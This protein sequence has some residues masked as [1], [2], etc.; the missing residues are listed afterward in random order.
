MCRV[1]FG[2]PEQLRD[3]ASRWPP[4]NEMRLGDSAKGRPDQIVVAGMGGSAIG[5]DL[6]AA[7]AA[8]HL[9]IPLLVWRNYRLPEFAG[10]KTLVVVS[11]YSGNTGEALSAYEEGRRRKCRLMAVTSGG[12][13][14]RRA[15]QESTEV[16]RLPQ[17]FPPRGA[18]AYSSMA[19]WAVL[20]DLKLVPD[21]RQEIFNAA[22]VLEEVALRYAPACPLERNLAKQTAYKLHGSFPVIYAA[23]DATSVAAVRWRGQLA[24]NAK[25]LSAH[26][27]L[28]EM[29]HNEIAGYQFPENVLKS[30]VVL[31]LRDPGEDGPMSRRMEVTSELLQTR[32]KSVVHLHGVG[33]TLTARLLSL[34]FLGDCVSFYTAVLNGVDPYP[35]EMIDTLK[36]RIPH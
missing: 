31:F 17:G 22:T 25:M 33:E 24:E 21:A 10:P 1:V 28:P 12:E 15:S 32:V 3:A 18:L 35:V 6:V 9:T 19:M 16:Y 13:L 7:L 5:G 29:N 4:R 2:L 27:L 30:V 34:I 11:S 23:A 26:H 20:R 14:G 8:D 36:N